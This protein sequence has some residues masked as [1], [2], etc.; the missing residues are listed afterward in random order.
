M[1]VPTALPD[2]AA[3]QEGSVVSRVLL[4]NRGGSVTLFA[5]AEGEGLSEH[6]TPFDALV[7]VTDGEAEVTVGGVPHRVRAGEALRLPAD[8]PHAVH[9]ARPFRMLL[10]MLRE[11]R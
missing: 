3:Y 11:P 6:A 9:A 2:L 5:F 1:N 8:V 10:T 7:V 4:K